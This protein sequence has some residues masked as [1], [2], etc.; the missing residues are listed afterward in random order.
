[1]WVEQ[2][3]SNTQRKNGDPKVDQ[4]WRPHRQRDVKEHDQR[5]HTKVDAWSC[6]PRQENTEVDACGCE[7]T[8]GCDVPSTSKSQIA[9]DRVRVNLCRKDFEHRGQ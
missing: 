5:P 4:V 9:Q 8:T 6:E 1:M 7:A 3:R 2:E